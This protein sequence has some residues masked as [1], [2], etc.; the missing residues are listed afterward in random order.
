MPGPLPLTPPAIAWRLEAGG[1]LHTSPTVASGTVFQSTTT[2]TLLAVDLGTGAI[3][4][5]ADLD[6]VLT[7]PTVIDDRVVVGSTLGWLKAFDRTT[8]GV[9]WTFKSAGQVRA[10]PAPFEDGVIIGSTGGQVSFVRVSDGATAWTV[11]VAGEVARSAAVAD[12]TVVLP[13]EPGSIVALDARSGQERWQTSI[14][15]HGGVGTPTIDA[16][17]V[18]TASG[19]GGASA[20]D[21]GIIAVDLESGTQLWRWASPTGDRIYTPAMRDR[22]AFVVSEAGFAVSLDPA[23]GRELWRTDVAGPAEANAVVTGDT[24]GIADDGGS[25]SALD[26]TDGSIRWQ[27]PIVGVPAAPVV[28]CGFVLIAT[29]LGTLTAFSTPS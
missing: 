24:V 19:L 11:D 6:G 26:A 10:A 2:G 25:V 5:Q 16:G 13:V 12:G 18:L 29:E 17:R 7:S 23:T 3:R 1:S 8:G 22:G 27:V 28:T 4:W 9:R 21:R 14:A 20:A 15:K